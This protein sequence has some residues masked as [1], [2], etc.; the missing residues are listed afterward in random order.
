MFFSQTPRLS[1]AFKPIPMCF[2][3]SKNDVKN[4]FMY[5]TC[6]VV[7]VVFFMKDNIDSHCTWRLRG[8]PSEPA[9][10]YLTCLLLVISIFRRTTG[11]PYHRFLNMEFTSIFSLT[12]RNGCLLCIKTVLFN[13]NGP[14]VSRE[15]W[16]FNAC[17]L[18]RPQAMSITCHLIFLI[19]RSSI[20]NYGVRHVR[21]V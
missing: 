20:I 6:T 5:M 9:A 16:L 19:H 1:R 14:P 10:V 13:L 2:H 7:A 18:I 21:K 4:A 15:G 17:M 3:K 12:S 11:M 8:T